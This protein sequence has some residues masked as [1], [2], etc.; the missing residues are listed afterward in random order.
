[1]PIRVINIID[2]FDAV[3]FGI[4]NAACATAQQLEF[5]HGIRSEL[6][7]PA[8]DYDP[9][10]PIHCEL[11]PLPSTTLATLTALAAQ[12]TP[13]NTIIVT[14]G[15]WQYPTRWGAAL[16]RKGF[17]WVYVPHGMLEPWS[18]S[19]KKWGKKAYWHLSESRNARHAKYVR[20]VG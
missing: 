7:F 8:T 15:C 13:H 12:L 5:R 17:T 10:Q 2:R 19:Q 20:A 1:M 9:Q 3:N 18:I 11:R 14:H 4:W 16:A 6:W